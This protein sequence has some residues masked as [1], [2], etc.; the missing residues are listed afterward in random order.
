MCVTSLL[1]C[2][3]VVVKVKGQGQGHGSRSTFWCAVVDIR[4]S[5]LPSATKSKEESL[6][7]EGVCL[8]VELSRECGRS[9]F[10]LLWFQSKEMAFSTPF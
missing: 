4:G 6:S 7:V 9:A 10:N 5:A 1:P 3:K 8:C 2:F